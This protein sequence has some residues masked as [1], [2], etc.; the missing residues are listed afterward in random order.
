M[1]NASG[2]AQ[3]TSD[4]FPFIN[5]GISQKLAFDA[6]ARSATFGP[7]TTVIR[8][9]ATQ[10]CHVMVATPATL[11][12]PTAVADGTALFLKSG[13]VEYIGVLPSSK[14]AAIKDSAGGNLF[15]TEGA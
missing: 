6:S 7:R 5:P 14:I 2:K 11:I 13:V 10:D 1:Q 15:I 3:S 12:T 8:I 9:C 4:G